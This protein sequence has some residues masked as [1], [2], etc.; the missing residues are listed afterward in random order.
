MQ[1]IP[2][3]GANVNAMSVSK[4]RRLRAN[5]TRGGKAPKA[6][7]GRPMQVRGHTL[8]AMEDG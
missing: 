5:I 4:A 7:D 2:D 8:D 6:A 3:T 1:A